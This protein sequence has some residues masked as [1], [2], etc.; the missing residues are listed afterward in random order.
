L[1][2]VSER[3]FLVYGFQ[4]TWRGGL[5]AGRPPLRDLGVDVRQRP[6]GGCNPYITEGRPCCVS[7]R[8]SAGR[9][10]LLLVLASDKCVD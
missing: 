8:G 3:D 5:L 6:V 2:A 10:L 1:A 7:L 9:S 4:G